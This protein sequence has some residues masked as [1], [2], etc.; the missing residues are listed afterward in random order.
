VANVDTL[1]A[2]SGSA[3]NQADLLNM[4]LGLVLNSNDLGSATLASVSATTCAA[5]PC[6][7]GVVYRFTAPNG[8]MCQGMAADTDGCS[9]ADATRGLGQVLL[10]GLPPNITAPAGWAAGGGYLIKMTS[11]SDSAQA[12]AG[13]GSTAPVVTSPVAGTGQV[14]YW[15]G[16][17]YTTCTL[18]A[19]GCGAGGTTIPAAA[20]NYTITL[21]G[22]H[23]VLFSIHSSMTAGGKTTTSIPCTGTCDR[24]QASATSAAPLI[25]SITYKV[26]YDGVTISNLTIH[27]DLG[28]LLASAS[29]QAAPNGS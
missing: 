15:N 19:V 25:G 14:S 4:G 22:I 18:Y 12:E 17:G 20:V 27:V 21:N 2:C 10:G 3:T 26:V 13:I 11:F 16:V 5:Q 9:H 8:T 28:T 29:Y 23:T 24:T 7:K 6:D 1:A